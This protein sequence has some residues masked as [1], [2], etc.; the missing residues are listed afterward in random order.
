MANYL[1]HPC[2]LYL[3]LSLL[4]RYC[5][6]NRQEYRDSP[7]HQ[8]SL[9]SVYSSGRLPCG[10]LC[11]KCWCAALS[12]SHGPATLYERC[13]NLDMLDDQDVTCLFLLVLHNCTRPL[14]YSAC[15]TE[16]SLHTVH[17]G[18]YSPC[19]YL[20]VPKMVEGICLP[21]TVCKTSANCKS[22]IHAPNVKLPQSHVNETSMSQISRFTSCCHPLACSSIHFAL[23]V[24][25]S[26][27]CA[28]LYI[29]ISGDHCQLKHSEV[30]T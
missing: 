26:V 20:L 23:Q 7:A 25:I 9:T 1:F 13:I 6:S 8:E 17:L 24:R 16:F 11:V 12:V 3:I 22:S 10:T 18:P 5:H 4:C 27:R 15:N 21:N 28:T 14:L 19:T 2:N 30:R 29:S